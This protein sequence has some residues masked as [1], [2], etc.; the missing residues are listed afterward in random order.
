MESNDSPQIPD[1][2]ESSDIPGLPPG[3]A[4]R[5]SLGIPNDFHV[6]INPGRLTVTGGSKKAVGDSW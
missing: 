3:A 2:G 6:L 4:E 1:R 5:K